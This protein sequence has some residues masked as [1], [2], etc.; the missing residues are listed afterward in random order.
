MNGAL[1]LWPRLAGGAATE[2]AAREEAL[3]TRLAGTRWL[4]TLVG[5]GVLLLAFALTVA[6]FLTMRG[7]GVLETP[8]IREYASWMPVGDLAI[9]WGL[10]L[11]QLSV[12]MALVITQALDS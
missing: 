7:A 12:L 3:T 5:P 8:F 6:L 4:T 2:L 1:V 9:T 11:D 10:Q